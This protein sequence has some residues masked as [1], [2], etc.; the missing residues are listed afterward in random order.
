ME[1]SLGPA[2]PRKTENSNQEVN[3]LTFPFAIAER[4]DG[5]LPTVIINEAKNSGSRRVAMFTTDAAQIDFEGAKVIPAESPEM[6]GD[7]FKLWFGTGYWALLHPQAHT[8]KALTPEAIQAMYPKDL[9]D[10]FLEERER[11][12]KKVSAEV[13][14][15]EFLHDYVERYSP[16]ADV[17]LKFNNAFLGPVDRELARAQTE[18]DRILFNF[19]DYFF[20]PTVEKM[21]P[22]IRKTGGLSTLH[23]HT[24]IPMIPE[25]V[26]MPRLVEDMARAISQ[27]DVVLTHTEVYNERLRL[28][29]NRLNL[30]TPELRTFSL[31]ID[32][33]DLLS[34]ESRI[35]EMRGGSAIEG[36]KSL[37][38]RQQRLIS[39]AF[40][41]DRMQIPHQFGV[42]DRLDPGKGIDTVF[43]AIDKF[44][45]AE[46]TRLS[47]AEIREKY[48]FFNLT[49]NFAEP[50]GFD[51][52]NM[53][54]S[55]T[56]YV[57][58][59]AIGLESKWPGVFFIS[60][61]LGGKQRDLIVA[62][63]RGR[64]VITGGAE[65][66][67]NQVVMESSFINR[68][69]PTAVIAGRNIGFVMEVAR[70]GL[71]DNIHDFQPGNVDELVERIRQ[72]VH[73][74]RLEIVNVIT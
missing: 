8:N 47:D 49:S 20:H 61:G 35:A 11:A 19:Q 4:P 46:R 53:K 3:Y 21:A 1:K 10:A 54:A 69:L 14:S 62:L 72:V 68:E 24:T 43:Q 65:D 16:P 39:A 27:V 2:T 67:L 22:V 56:D 59:L 73:I 25:N 58:R 41:A 15:Q 42:Y 38:S 51:A 48:R 45:T 26:P 18:G 29:M 44:L 9:V 50:G 34:R 63:M 60:E 32:E 57:T 37:T 30:R 28:I 66:G 12:G 71:S 6:T 13:G 40:E 36:F 64:H 23:L 55:Y 70:S 33:G 7:L 5:G 31:G 52:S 17:N 74:P